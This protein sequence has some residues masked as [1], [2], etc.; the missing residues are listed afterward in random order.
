MSPED[1]AQ[2]LRTEWNSVKWE[3]LMPPQKVGLELL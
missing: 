1:E 3:V 2:A